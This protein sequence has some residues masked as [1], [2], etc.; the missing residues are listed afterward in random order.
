MRQYDI[1][2]GVLEV[3]DGEE[4]PIDLVELDSRISS[5]YDAMKSG[6]VLPEPWLEMRV[7]DMWLWGVNP[8]EEIH[9]DVMLNKS[10]LLGLFLARYMATHYQVAGQ[11]KMEKLLPAPLCLF[12]GLAQTWTLRQLR[13]TVQNLQVHWADARAYDQPHCEPFLDACMCRL[14]QLAFDGGSADVL[15]DQG[16]VEDDAEHGLRLTKTT[17]RRFVSALH[18]LYRHLAIQKICVRIDAPDDAFFDCKFTFHNMQGACDEFQD[19][20]MHYALAPGHKILYVHDFP[21]DRT[22]HRSPPHCPRQGVLTQS[23]L[24]SQE[25]TIPSRKWFI[26]TMQTMCKPFMTAA[27]NWPVWANSLWSTWSLSCATCTLTLSSSTSV[28][29]S[30]NLL[31]KTHMGFSSSHDACTSSH[32]NFAF[33]TTPT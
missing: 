32:Q 2:T 17:I 1:G 7:W 31:P 26:F 24:C 8:H 30:R 15:N 22:H 16:S 28:T 20:S 25:C 4:P 13:D 19:I 9:Q 6:S 11:Q 23:L 21:G 10:H 14:G 33:I 27:Q 3:E 12:P 18:I 29:T 5:E